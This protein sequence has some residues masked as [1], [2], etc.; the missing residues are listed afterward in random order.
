MSAPDPMQQKL[1]ARY[2]RAAELM[3]AYQGF[4]PDE[5]LTAAETFDT[6]ALLA[7]FDNL[8]VASAEAAELA[9]QLRRTA[10]TRAGRARFFPEF[11]PWMETRA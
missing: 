8:P 10:P 9:D 3:L 4:S 6:L 11:P 2:R 7:S 1:P 5:L